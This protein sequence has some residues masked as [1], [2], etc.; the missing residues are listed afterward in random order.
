MPTRIDGDLFAAAKTAGDVND[1]S[2]AQ[3]I[4]HWARL[5]RE[6]ERSGSVSQ[7]DV[8]RV[9]AHASAYDDASEEVQAAVRVAW[10][11]R[12]LDGIDRLDLAARFAADGTR[13]SEADADGTV[14]THPGRP[15]A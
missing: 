10:D 15:T 11:E 2:A 13:H 9:L 1:R 8:E 4:T 7:R 6:L 14:T 3:Q 5:G 12:L